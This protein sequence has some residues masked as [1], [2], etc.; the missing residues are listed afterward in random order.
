MCRNM[1]Q[2]L[3]LLGSQLL[4]GVVEATYYI[5]GGRLETSWNCSKIV[6]CI[7]IVSEFMIADSYTV[8]KHESMLL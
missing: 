2:R 3:S 8:D 4:V 5:V 7:G 1:H 6:Q